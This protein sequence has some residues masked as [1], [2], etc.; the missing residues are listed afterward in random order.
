MNKN[1]LIVFAKNKLYGKVKTRLAKTIG[2]EGAFKVYAHLYKITEKESCGVENAIVR[3]YY[4]HEN[5]E[6]SWLGKE[7]F[8][9]E[10][11]TLGERMGN[12]FK[13]GFDDGFE[14]IIGIG[15]DLAEIKTDIIEDA[16]VRLENNDFVFGP[17]EDGGYYLVG[18][19]GEKGMYVFEDKPWSTPE[20][21][22]LTKKEILERKDTI[23]TIQMLNDI[24]TIEDLKKSSIGTVFA[25]LIQN[26]QEL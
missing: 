12:A 17:A 1:L 22:E 16:F 13:K 21:F 5:D 19:S 20:L 15:A 8:V 3:V 9:Q 26:R 7:H 11:E 14:N 25:N 23:N 24:D 2:D 6:T 18:I 10:G 4:S